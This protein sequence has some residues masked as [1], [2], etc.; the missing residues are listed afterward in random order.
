VRRS[1][2]AANCHRGDEREYFR[3]FEQEVLL[4]ELLAD[5]D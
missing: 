2:D 4:D 3:I 1:A 5:P